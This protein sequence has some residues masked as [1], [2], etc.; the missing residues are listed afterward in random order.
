MVPFY[1][2]ITVH[3]LVLVLDRVHQ[4]TF[5]GV[6]RNHPINIATLPHFLDRRG[7]ICVL[8]DESM[9]ASPG[10]KFVTIV[11]YIRCIF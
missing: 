7:H 5:A 2:K 9:I 10:I 11:S 8:D 3:K 1:F 4:P 6:W